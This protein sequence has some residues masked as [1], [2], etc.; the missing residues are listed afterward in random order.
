[1]ATS[2][3]LR[4]AQQSFQVLITN[5]HFST[6]H[7]K[8]RTRS[9]FEPS[10]RYL[11]GHNYVGNV[12]PEGHM[13]FQTTFKKQRWCDLC[14]ME[15]T[16]GTY[17]ERCKVCASYDICLSCAE[18][19]GPQSQLPSA[20]VDK[21]ANAA[22]AQASPARINTVASIPV[23]CTAHAATA[24][25]SPARIN[26]VASIPVA[27]TAQCAAIGSASYAAA[28]QAKS[29]QI[30]SCIVAGHICSSQLPKRNRM[31]LK[32]RLPKDWWIPW[33]WAF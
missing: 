10:V 18:T 7:L 30:H 8:Y 21:S 31:K 3:E 13:L 32:A 9:S 26:T 20:S 24:Q 12:C 17:G 27:C 16:P 33:L 4:Q 14:V 22:T 19:G 28:D 29:I 2:H 11:A 5:V 23:A 25:A 1:V 15:L 6:R